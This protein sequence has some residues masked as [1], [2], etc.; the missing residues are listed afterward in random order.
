MRY[1]KSQTGSLEVER[2]EVIKQDYKVD[3]ANVYV[4]RIRSKFSDSNSSWSYRTV[5]LSDK[6]TDQRLSAIS[7]EKKAELVMSR[8][9]IDSKKKSL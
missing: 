3:P 2:D 5:I 7:Q 6:R 1:I 8:K 9:A 4:Y